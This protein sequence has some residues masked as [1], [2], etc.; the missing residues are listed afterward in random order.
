MD[1][2]KV[3]D[4][5]RALLNL[6]NNSAAAQGEIDNAMRFAASL[7]EKHQ[8]TEE[9]VADVGEK[10]LDLENQSFAELKAWFGGYKFCQWESQAASF[11]CAFVGGVKWYY[12]EG[13]PYRDE[14]GIVQ[15]FFD[16]KTKYRTQV[17]FYGIAEDVEIAFAVYNELLM[18]VASMAKLKWNSVY[19]GAGRNYCEGFLAGL[20]SKWYKDKD[21]QKKLA[22]QPTSGSTALAV[23]DGRALIVKRKEELTE[24]WLEKQRGI[25]LKS[26]KRSHSGSF[27]ATAHNDGRSDGERYKASGER[28]RKLSAN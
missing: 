25:K 4:N 1:R 27:D 18:T 23:I 17:T 15:T 22:H 21:S 10:V 7:M 2:Q 24:Q 19:R 20:W 9:D 28:N 3:V 13:V 6:A 11:A 5:I 8:L 12:N 26:Q 16:G 14:H